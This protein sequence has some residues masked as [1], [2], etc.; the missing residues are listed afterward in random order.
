MTESEHVADDATDELESNAAQSKNQDSIRF[1]E[2]EDIILNQDSYGIR[3]LDTPEGRNSASMLINK[4][5]AWRGYAGSH[6]FTN[7]P[8]R[9]TLTASDKGDVVGTVTIGI[10]STVGLAGDMIFK[11]ELDR[12]RAD[13]AKLCE[14]TKLAF[15]TAVRSKTALANLFHLAVLYARDLHDC[16]DIIIEINP[17]HRRF[18]EYML[19]FKRES[20][21]KTNPRVNAPA[22]LLRVNMDY[23]TE[24]IQKYGGTWASEPTERS[25]YPFFFSP[26]EEEGIRARLLNID[27]RQSNGSH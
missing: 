18:Y 8:N 22:Y 3:L 19:G 20:E 10:D 2:E 4:M 25:F 9:I 13:G 11:D 26:R 14:F 17:R 15:D 5:Y 21:L 27:G 23:V 1:S 6:A 7:D 24:Q 12:L 16:T